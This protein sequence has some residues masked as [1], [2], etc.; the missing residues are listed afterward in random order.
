MSRTEKILWWIY[1]ALI[2][3]TAFTGFGNMPLYKRYYISNLPGLGWSGDFLINVRIHYLTGSILLGVG[4]YF[5]AMYVSA[6]KHRMYL[7]VTGWLRAVFLALSLVSGIIMALKNLPF[8]TFTFGW[9]V[10]MNFLHLG[11]AMIFVFLSLGCFIARAKWTKSN[12]QHTS[13]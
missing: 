8:V 11:T 10:A 13:T 7:S 2:V 12:H 1:V 9:L 4:V 5:L 3:L 6:W